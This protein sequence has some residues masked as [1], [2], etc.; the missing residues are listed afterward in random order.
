MDL[1]TTSV[2][3]I[4]REEFEILSEYRRIFDQ[5][6]LSQALQLRTLFEVSLDFI[7]SKLQR[8][9]FND[10]TQASSDTSDELLTA[11]EAAEILNVSEDWMYQHASKLPFT[12]RLSRK[13]LRFSKR[14]LIRYRD[15]SRI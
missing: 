12:K 10:E 2:A 9:V 5:M 3:A 13:A 1:E 6:T 15:A 7:N 8:D 4:R 11:K 14:G